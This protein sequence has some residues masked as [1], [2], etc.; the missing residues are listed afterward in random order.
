MNELDQLHR[1]YASIE[2]PASLFVK[3]LDL[4]QKEDK[5]LL[6]SGDYKFSDYSSLTDS[7]EDITEYKYMGNWENYPSIVL[8]CDWWNSNAPNIEMRIA[9]SFHISVRQIDGKTYQQINPENGSIW[10]K[11]GSDIDKECKAYVGNY[12]LISFLKKISLYRQESGFDH[13]YVDY[14]DESETFDVWGE[15]PQVADMAYRTYQELR[16]FSRRYSS[17]WNSIKLLAKENQL[18]LKPKGFGSASLERGR[19]SNKSRKK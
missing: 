11:S 14:V 7:A 9:G 6:T 16:K 13:F 3:A 12:L 19:N 15:N 17:I 5:N 18:S 8:I 4:M 10:I 2:M 1:S